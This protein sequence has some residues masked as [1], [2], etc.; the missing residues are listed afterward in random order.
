VWWQLGKRQA[1]IIIVHNLVHYL[2]GNFVSI[3]YRRMN[4]ILRGYEGNSLVKGLLPAALVLII[5]KNASE[6]FSIWLTVTI[7]LFPVYS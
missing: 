6:E 7:I 2:P 3:T 4:V 1:G 5:D